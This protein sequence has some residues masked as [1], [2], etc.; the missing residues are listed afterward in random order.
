M[1]DPFA[2]P[3][4]ALAAIADRYDVILSDVWG[5]LHN[6]VAAYQTAGA[7]LAGFRARGGKVVLITNAPRPSAPIVEMMDRLGVPREAWDG[8]V[9]SGD[10]TRAMIAPYAGQVVHHVGPATTDDSLY[11]GLGVTRGPAEA[12]AAVVVTDVDDDNARPEDYLPRLRAWK[13]RN[14]PLICA[15]PD[16]IVEIG[17]R[18]FYCAGA[19]ADLYEEIGGTV[20][21]AGKPYAPIYE[22]ALHL[23]EKAVGHPVRRQRVLAIGDSVRTD[24][25]GAAAFGI[26]LLFITGSVHAEELDAFGDHDAEAVR[27]LLAPVGAAVA[28]Y[29]ARLA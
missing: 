15:N 4:P 5:V 25:A 10:C 17:D 22:D 28:G 1:T 23:A 16:K 19:I 18:F 20:L 27:T 11:E 3:L 26:D 14:L 21:Q 8:I 12:A 24:A 29:M 13:A 7:A 2:G 9:S 6:G